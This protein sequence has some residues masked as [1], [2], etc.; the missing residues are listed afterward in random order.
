[1]EMFLLAT[2]EITKALIVHR[3]NTMLYPTGSNGFVALAD[4]YLKKGDRV[5]A[6]LNYEHA[7][8]LQPDNEKA[9]LMLAQLMK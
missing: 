9:T 5:K 7:L 3:L 6:K 8:T 2:N 1:M 4:A